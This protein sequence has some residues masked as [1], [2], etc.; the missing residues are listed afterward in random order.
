MYPFCL[1][2][3]IGGL[4]AL[5]DVV[6]YMAKLPMTPETASAGHGPRARREFTRNTACAA[7]RERRGQ[8]GEAHPASTASTTSTSCGRS[9]RSRRQAA[10][11]QPRHG[12]AGG[13]SSRS[14]DADRGSATIRPHQAAAT[15][16]RSR[17]TGNRTDPALTAP[18]RARLPG[19]R[20]FR[21]PLLRRASSC[22][23]LSQLLPGSH[24]ARPGR[25]RPCCRD[26][27]RAG[28]WSPEGAGT[29][30]PGPSRTACQ[31]HFHMNGV[32]NGCKK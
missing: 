2:I 8:R 3:Q 7:R 27:L 26:L 14:G 6:A 10:Q 15:W 23:T 16:W 28:L 22:D 32:F 21:R 12:Q 20:L 1:P 18:R 24:G 25:R 5:A 13:R 4:A 19:Q 9:G 30:R 29:I 31:I 11:C 17:R